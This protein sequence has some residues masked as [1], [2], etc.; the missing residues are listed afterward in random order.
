[1]T[2]EVDFESVAFFVADHAVVENGKIY[3]NGA[4]WNRLAF[5]VYPALVSFTIAAAVR[6]PWRAYH[7]DHKF[8]IRLVDGHGA[9][10][11][12]KVE[13]QFRVGTAPDMQT[14]EATLMPL[15]VSVNNFQLD[16]PGE[17]SLVLSIDGSE[18]SRYWLKAVQVIAP[19]M[20]TPPLA[21]GE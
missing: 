6:V 13:G 4:F 9:E 5:P 11:G 10:L 2:N 3:A 8:E 12:L 7:Q 16:Q 17:Y 14:G 18:L 20:M 1:M 19:F 21:S 15:A